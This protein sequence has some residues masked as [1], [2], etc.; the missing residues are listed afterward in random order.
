MVYHSIKFLDFYLKSIKCFL[1]TILGVASKKMASWE[2]FKRT[3][4]LLQTHVYFL[5]VPCNFTVESNRS[6][7][8]SVCLTITILIG[9]RANIKK[10]IMVL[11]NYIIVLI[12]TVMCWAIYNVYANTNGDYNTITLHYDIFL[13]LYRPCS[14]NITIFNRA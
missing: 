11:L 6:Y 10:S 5:A 1:L 12:L 3:H 7:Y 4:Y 14:L 2:K 8:T 13:L 9:V